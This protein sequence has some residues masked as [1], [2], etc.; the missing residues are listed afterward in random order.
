MKEHAKIDA[1]IIE[2]QKYP[3]KV[4]IDHSP[5]DLRRIVEGEVQSLKLPRTKIA[6]IVNKTAK[7]EGLTWNR[8]LCGSDGKVLEVVAGTMLLVGWNQDSDKY[9]SLSEEQLVLFEDRFH[10]PE[11]FYILN[12]T[13]LVFPYTPVAE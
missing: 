4:K 3:R 10:Q 2:P 12:G 8:A 5:A 13:L 11:S 7:R 9:C 1:L 6:I